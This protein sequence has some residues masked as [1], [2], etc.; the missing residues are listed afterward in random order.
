MSVYDAEFV[1]LARRLG[2][3]L[4]TADGAILEGAPDV[5][6]HI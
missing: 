6:V 2:V 3:D 5:A 1:A 4:V